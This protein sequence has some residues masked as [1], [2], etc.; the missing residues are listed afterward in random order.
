MICCAWLSQYTICH[1]ITAALHT[2]LYSVI[3]GK[4]MVSSIGQLQSC[5]SITIGVKN[6]INLAVWRIQQVVDATIL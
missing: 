1:Y 5:A 3:G 2:C 4:R 6:F